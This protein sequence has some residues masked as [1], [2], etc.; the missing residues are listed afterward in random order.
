[1]KILFVCACNLNR[2]P[3]FERVFR[4]LCPQHEVQSAGADYGYPNKLNQKLVDWADKIFVMDISQ[5][6]FIRKHFPDA[7]SKVIIVGVSDQYDVDS[8]ELVEIA[9]Y[10]VNHYF[11]SSP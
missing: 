9:E 3:T 7:M 8:E 5:E 11:V 1:M 4:R 6:M 10:W 2:S